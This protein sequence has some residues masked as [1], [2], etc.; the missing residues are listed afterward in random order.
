MLCVFHFIC[1]QSAGEVVQ[2]QW[3]GIRGVDHDAGMRG[4]GRGASQRG[5]GVSRH[6]GVVAQDGWRSRLV[7]R[8]CAQCCGR[9]RG[10]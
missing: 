7:A 3:G 9:G 8:E 2:C 10:R 5:P 6:G 4:H 1:D